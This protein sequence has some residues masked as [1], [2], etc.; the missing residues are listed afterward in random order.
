MGECSGEAPGYNWLGPGVGTYL[1]AM[2]DEGE[3]LLGV[4]FIQV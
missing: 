2:G 4:S 1:Q 3:A